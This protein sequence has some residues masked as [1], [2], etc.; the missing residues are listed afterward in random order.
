[1]PSSITLYSINVYITFSQ[2]T[3]K[4]GR[5]K[6][7][8][9]DVTSFKRLTRPNAEGS[10][11]VKHRIA[12]CEVKSSYPPCCRSPKGEIRRRKRTGENLKVVLGRVFH[13]KIDRFYV[14]KELCGANEQPR[15]KLNTLLAHFCPLKDKF[16]I[17]V[18][19]PSLGPL[20]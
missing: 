6:K 16:Q 8:T 1:M 9:H 15:L 18:S 10:T 20:L 3:L 14:V 12:F 13:F 5:V 2:G 7:Y 11:V 17:G 19:L 4:R